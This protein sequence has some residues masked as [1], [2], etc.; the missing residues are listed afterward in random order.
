[1]LSPERWAQL[2]PILDG[3]LDLRLEQRPAYVDSLRS[4]DPALA[5]E[6]E[7]LIAAGDARSSLF[8]RAAADRFELLLRE[9]PIGLPPIL[10][11]RF[12]IT[13][14]IGRGGMSTV[15]E[16]RDRKHDRTVAVKVVRPEFAA[17]VGV[18]RF[19]REIKVVAGLEHPHIVSLYDS[20][21]DEGHLYFVMPF[22]RGGSLRSRLA[23]DRWL[24][25]DAA[26]RVALD[27]GDALG[28]LHARGLV[29]R[30]VKPENILFDGDRALLADFGIARVMAAEGDQLTL[31]GVSVG[32]PTYMSP[33]QA[34]GQSSIDARS[35]VYSLAC[36]VYEMLAGEPPFVAS[37]RRGVLA[38]HLSEPAPPLTS[39]GPRVPRA[40]GAAVSRA[41]AKEPADR[42]ASVEAF[43]SA[44]SASDA[45]GPDA[46]VTGD[47][48]A[49]SARGRQ[50]LMS[51]AGG[52]RD[53]VRAALGRLSARGRVEQAVD[54]RRRVA[55]VP[56]ENL[57]GDASLAVV[58]RIA[59]NWLSQGIMQADTVVVVS[60][61]TVDEVAAA[62]DK[63]GADMVRRLA[64]AAGVD[65]VVTGTYARRGD[66]LIVQVNVVNART[67]AVIR[68]IQSVDGPLS[69]PLVAITEARERVLGS[70]VSDDVARS[71]AVTGQAPKYSAYREFEAGVAC[72]T[73]AEPGRSRPFFERAI[74]LDPTFAQAY[75]RLADTYW[76][77][78]RLDEV[79]RVLADLD[80]HRDRLSPVERLGIEEYRAELRGDLE[81]AFDATR[82]AW[83]RSADPYYAFVVGEIGNGLLRPREALA[84]LRAAAD[85]DRYRKVWAA[86][87][88][89]MAESY[90]LLGQYREQ[91]AIAGQGWTRF[92]R[93]MACAG[94]RLRAYAGLRDGD[95]AAAFAST[96]LSDARPDDASAADAVL[97]AALEFRVHGGTD[98][99]RRLVE[100]VVAWYRRQPA[101]SP[102]ASH[103]LLE[104]RAL[105]VLG[106]LE[107]AATQLRNVRGDA[108]DVVAAGYLG[109]AAA[110]RGDAS[111]ARQVIDSI[112]A[113]DRRWDR[114]ETAFWCA[115][116]R[117][118]LGERNEAVALLR[119]AHRE[120][121]RM[122]SWHYH[123]ALSALRDSSAFH[124]LIQR[125]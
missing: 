46:V 60:G 43:V 24:P 91:L 19:L 53:A 5:A 67:R 124:E 35:D 52:A 65:I 25:M 72:H 76:N 125:S 121:Q 38:K 63:P 100:M 62:I 102:S 111:E 109:V 105:L 15:Y 3:V 98:T 4:R 66:R 103:A 21:D 26:R 18:E 78:S 58:G 70:L 36:V 83:K 33:E 39:P 122:A 17:A 89:E 28:Y 32:T 40:V 56:F 75:V 34:A 2:E 120:G 117:G 116:I 49:A 95:R 61:T 42:F 79:E 13:R 9:A 90:H 71:I 29:H 48:R 68:A 115:A 99:A 77:E 22:V 51:L 110:R 87:L 114:G 82:E 73:P 6:F 7:R 96:L 118:E 30:D 47:E 20:G 74:A 10:G 107:A 97:T 112:A 11:G 119:R 50:S 14:E 106:E 57:T 55:V 84:A 108:M 93:D 44:L 94:Q 45:S 37:S 27:I 81:A 104:G 12:E 86:P 92:P 69:D 64:S 59:A 23:R 8:D 54:S 41:L 80:A 16:A 113:V 101:R 31:S 1:M 85:S 123:D 88:A